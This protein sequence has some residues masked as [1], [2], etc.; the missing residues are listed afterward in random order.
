[1]RTSIS[2]DQYPKVAQLP[3]FGSG[4]SICPNCHPYWIGGSTGQWLSSGSIHKGLVRGLVKFS[5]IK[6]STIYL[7]IIRNGQKSCS[8]VMFGISWPLKCKP[9]DG[10]LNARRK[11]KRLNFWQCM[12]RLVSKL[13]HQK[14]KKIPASAI[15]RKLKNNIFDNY[16]LSKI[17]LNSLWVSEKSGHPQNELNFRA[18][19]GNATILEKV[20][21]SVIPA[22][23]SLSIMTI[24][25]KSTE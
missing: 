10:H 19:L 3:P 7:G 2:K 23:F 9:A 6:V 11:N 17:C 1:M 20:R 24:A 8:L 13:I 12:Q 25:D 4:T 14:W 21:W 5:V 18:N 22:N 16:F 15:L